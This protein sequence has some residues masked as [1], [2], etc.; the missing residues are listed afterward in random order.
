MTPESKGLLATA[1]YKVQ[2]IPLIIIAPYE[3]L[4][5]LRYRAFHGIYPVLSDG[6]PAQVGYRGTG[7]AS[8][9]GIQKGSLDL[10]SG[11]GHKGSLPQMIEVL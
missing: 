5:A 1:R 11:L 8:R 6:K 10:W 2:A 4:S 7:G 3:R 9:G